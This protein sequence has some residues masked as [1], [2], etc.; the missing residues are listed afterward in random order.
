MIRRWGKALLFSVLL[1]GAVCWLEGHEIRTEEHALFAVGVTAENG[2]EEEI[3]CWQN[4]YTE[5]YYVFLPSYG[6]EQGYRLCLNKGDCLEL[7]GEELSQDIRL[8]GEELRPG[9]EYSFCLR[10]SENRV[11][12]SG[13]LS[14]QKSAR[15]AALYIDTDNED[16]TKIKEDQSLKEPGKLRIVTAEGKEDAAGKLSYIKGRGNATWEWEKKPYALKLDKKTD[17]LHM[18]AGSTWVLLANYNDDSG[19]RNKIVYDLAEKI[20]LSYSPDSE[21]VDL[22]INGYY[23]GLYQ[24]AE[25]I[26]V[27]DSRV[28]V[29]DLEEENK[30]VNRKTGMEEVFSEEKKKGVE[31]VRDPDDITGGYL[32]ELD[33]DGRYES[34]LSG[35]ITE[36]GQA[37][38]LKGPKHASRAEIDYISELLQECENAIYGENGINPDTGKGI[39]D[40]LDLESWTKKYLIEEIAKNFDAGIS[41]NFIYKDSDL[42][43]TG[44][45]YAGP[46]WDYDFALGNGD[47]SIRKPEGMI[48]DQDIRIYVPE[49]GDEVFRNRWFSALYRQEIFREKLVEEYESC[50]KA[51]VEEMVLTGIDGYLDQIRDAW[52]MNRQRWLGEPASM[53]R[54]YRDTLEEHG[55]YLKNF[56]EKRLAFLDTVWIDR[57]DYCTVT[58]YTEYGSRNFYFQ[59]ERGKTVEKPPSYEESFD[60]EVFAGWY[61]DEAC[62]RPFEAEAPITEDTEVY[63]KWIA[64]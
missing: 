30:K 50:V 55:E 2:A 53:Q 18:G 63:A 22:Y 20:G 47:W 13:S 1:A 41:S 5:E 9:E 26:E 43:G 24:L 10:D 48:V 4:P 54:I 14:V 31:L 56:L 19:V 16:L 49:K 7:D 59:V 39:A 38:D 6:E 52:E 42:N 21:F 40:Y 45:I 17:L 44:L 12:A 15:V 23:E 32:M 29:A 11:T 64:E 35:F 62:T 60:G 34:A 46:V 28:H 51:A 8:T 27:G 33:I 3:E 25:K 57:L 36:Q 61:Y 58:F 37:V